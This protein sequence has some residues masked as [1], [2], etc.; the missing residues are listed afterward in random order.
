MVRFRYYFKGGIYLLLD[1]IEGM[2][3][4]EEL[5]GSLRFRVKKLDE[6]IWGNYRRNRFVGVI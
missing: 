2:I 6:Y 1:C 5:R 3:E 4:R